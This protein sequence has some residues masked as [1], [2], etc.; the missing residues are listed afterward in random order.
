MAFFFLFLFFLVKYW[1]FHLHKPFS[2]NPLNETIW[3]GKV[4]ANNPNWGDYLLWG[5][6]HF[7]KVGLFRAHGVWLCVCSMCSLYPNKGWIIERVKN[8]KWRNTW[9]SPCR[10]DYSR[11]KKKRCKDDANCEQAFW[12]VQLRM[13]IDRKYRGEQT[14]GQRGGGLNRSA[15]VYQPLPSPSLF[16]HSPFSKL[17]GWLH[18]VETSLPTHTPPFS[19]SHILFLPH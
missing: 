6:L 18:Y 5:V 9:F 8:K 17:L 1:H 19:P 16:S 10:Q 11:V 13:H 12:N 15:S 4:I 2:K 3:E 7:V 14:C